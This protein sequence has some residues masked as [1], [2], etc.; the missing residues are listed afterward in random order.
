MPAIRGTDAA[1]ARHGGTIAVPSGIT[2]LD[3]AWYASS[4]AFRTPIENTGARRITVFVLTAVGVGKTTETR[5]R[6][7]VASRGRVGATGV[8]TAAFAA[9][10]LAADLVLARTRSIVVALGAS[11]RFLEANQPPWAV[12]RIAAKQIA[13]TS[14]VD[15]HERRRTI[16]VFVT[17]HAKPARGVANGPKRIDAI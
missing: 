8:A 5:A 3:A 9:N 13:F 2:H 15:A 12:E 4:L 17:T 1:R 16:R 7:Y 11:C 10:A 6:G 14:A